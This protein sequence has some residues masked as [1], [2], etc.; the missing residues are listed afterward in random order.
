MASDGDGT[1]K[2]CESITDP[3]LLKYPVDDTPN[4]RAT[5]SSA[6]RSH[7]QITTNHSQKSADLPAYA[8]AVDDTKNIP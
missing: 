3:N 8:D 5:V 1:K 4:Q 7:N 2:A 6:Y